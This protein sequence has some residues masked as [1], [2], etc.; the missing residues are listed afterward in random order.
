M[1]EPY[2]ERVSTQSVG[3]FL[4][5][6]QRVPMRAGHLLAAHWLQSEVCNGGF[7]QFF[8]NPTGVLAPEAIAGLW[9]IGLGDLADVAEQAAAFFGKDYP[10]DAESR[11]AALD[12]F[13]RRQPTTDDDD[14][15]SWN[16][17]TDLDERFFDLLGCDDG[18]D[19]FEAAADAYSAAGDGPR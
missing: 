15:E 18:E 3:T 4:R 5:D 9:A 11:S 17:F 19:R 16:P 7:H 1:V 10:R 2:W 14:D 12:A 8:T 13:A 6:F